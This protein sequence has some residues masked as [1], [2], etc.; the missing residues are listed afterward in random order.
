MRMLYDLYGMGSAEYLAA[1]QQAMWQRAIAESVAA[2]QYVPNLS[3][4]NALSNYR[5]AVFVPN[6]WAEWSAY[7][8]TY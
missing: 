5:P 2:S 3:D 6:G 1:Q 4:L 7:G 8:T